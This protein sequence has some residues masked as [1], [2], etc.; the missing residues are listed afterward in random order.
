MVSN[1][2]LVFGNC[3]MV[4]NEPFCKTV[5]RFLDPFRGL[6]FEEMIFTARGRPF[7]QSERGLQGEMWTMLMR[8]TPSADSIGQTKHNTSRATG[9]RTLVTPVAFIQAATLSRAPASGSEG[10]KTRAGKS[11]AK[12]TTCSPDP[13]ATPSMTPRCRQDITKDIENEIAI[14]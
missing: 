4:C 2:V 5:P 3:G 7:Y 6:V 9:A 11:L 1:S 13:L 12:W 8:V 14:P 10:W